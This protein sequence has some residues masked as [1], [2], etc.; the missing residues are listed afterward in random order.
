MS[1]KYFETGSEI[2]ASEF[3]HIDVTSID[4]MSGGVE[5]LR[6]AEAKALASQI[7]ALT[8]PHEAVA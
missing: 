1:G 2:P 4:A 7:V 8:E 5:N 3:P 6:L